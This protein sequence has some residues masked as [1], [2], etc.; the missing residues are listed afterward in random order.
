MNQVDNFAIIDHHIRSLTSFV[1]ETAKHD[2][3]FFTN[4]VNVY[5]TYKKLNWD[6]VMFLFRND[7]TLVHSTVNVLYWSTWVLY[8]LWVRAGVFI[9]HISLIGS[10][11]TFAR[12]WVQLVNGE[13][14]LQKKDSTLVINGTQVLADMMVIAA[15][16]PHLDLQAQK[17]VILFLKWY[18]SHNLTETCT[19]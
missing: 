18:F 13:T 7:I 2:P 11:D 1:S 12:V 5:L 8:W 10:L 3:G 17:L 6:V 15:A 16:L 4:N 19:S 9:V 14:L